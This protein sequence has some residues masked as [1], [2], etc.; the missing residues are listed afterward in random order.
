MSIGNYEDLQHMPNTYR[1]EWDNQTVVYPMDQ[2]DWYGT[3][4]TIAQEKFPQLESFEDLHLYLKQT[5]IP[6]LI[7]YLQ[8]ACERNDVLDQIDTF[9]ARILYDRTDLEWMIQR[10][11][12][13]RIVTP[14]QEKNGRLL[15]F[16]KDAW[17]G[18]G[19]GIKNVWTP[20]TNSYDSNSMY[21]V[22]LENSN[23]ISQQV[24]DKQ[25]SSSA[26]QDLC[27][28]H[29]TPLQI[30]K[31]NSYLFDSHVI[32]GNLNNTTG[33]TRVSMDGR[34]LLRGG[35]F[36]KKIPGGY[37]RFLGE[38]TTGTTLQDHKNWVTY[39]GWNGQYT[40][41]IPI[42]LQRMFINNYCGDKKININDYQFESETLDWCPNLEAFAETD[43][44]DGIVCFSIFGLP[45][46]PFRR[47]SILKCA[48]DN[49]TELVFANED[50]V[51]RTIADI[52]HIKKLYNFY[53]EG[54]SE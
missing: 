36:N 40:K 3:W 27:L 37:F 22:S 28:K 51:C 30:D 26:I 29:A 35:I 9:Y 24:Y 10:T 20:I 8:K 49:N 31:G 38:R 17:T 18:N 41:S 5:E 54:Q 2:F 14:D 1:Q 45:D 42:H 25:L 21:V 16:H 50:V 7:Y 48:V 52:E 15:Q 39:A 4:L 11:L 46:N 6:E 32:H 23:M 47:H 53:K 33:K 19:P 43:G 34:I 13:I 12:N 44:I